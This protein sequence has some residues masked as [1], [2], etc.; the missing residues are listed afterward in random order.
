MYRNGR[1]VTNVVKYCQD[2][3]FINAVDEDIKLGTSQLPVALFD[4]IIVWGKKLSELQ[5]EKLF[6][7][8]KGKLSQYLSR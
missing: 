3:S 1:R 8:Y 7:F 4:D 6:R 2:D 5:V